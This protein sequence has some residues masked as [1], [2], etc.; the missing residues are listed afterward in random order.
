MNCRTL[1]SYCLPIFRNPHNVTY[2]FALR[3]FCVVAYTDYAFVSPF[4]LLSAN[5]F[6]P[7]F[8]LYVQVTRT[9]DLHLLQFLTKPALKVHNS[10][11]LLIIFLKRFNY[12]IG[13]AQR[14][15]ETLHLDMCSH[16]NKRVLQEEFWRVD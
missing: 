16:T 8:F 3:A 11:Y 12:S 1:N 10:I 13:S 14:I 6:F 15:R 7:D 5:S 9:D 4:F 2:P